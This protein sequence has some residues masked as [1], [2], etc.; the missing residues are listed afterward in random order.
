MNKKILKIYIR[1]AINN[2]LRF[3]KLKKSKQEIDRLTAKG[4]EM[5]HIYPPYEIAF[6]LVTK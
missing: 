2:R 1:D 6:N 4:L 3:L 5:C